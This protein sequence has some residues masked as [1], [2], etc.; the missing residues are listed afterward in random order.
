MADISVTDIGKAFGENVILEHISF[1]IQPGQHVGLVGANGTGKTSLFRMLSGEWEPDGGSIHV[2]RGRRVGLLAQL[3]R[4]SPGATVEDVLRGAFAEREALADQLRELEDKMSA[5]T[6]DDE[7][8]R[9]YGELQSRFEASGGYNSDVELAKVAAGLDITHLLPREFERISGGE[10]TRANLARLILADTDILLLDEP[11]N[12]LD[13]RSVEW[14]E[15]YLSACRST[16]IIVSHDR[17]FLDRT[18]SR[19]IELEFHTATVWEGN[20][21]AYAMQKE[22]RLADQEKRWEQEQREIARLSH[23]AARMHGWGMGNSKLQKRAFALDK[24]IERLRQTEKV[25]RDNVVYKGGF[26]DAEESGEEVLELHGL[27]KAFGDHVLFSEAEGFIRKGESV[28]ILGDNGT[29]KTT[30]LKILLGDE[31]SDA[32]KVRWGAN[33]R[34]AYLPQVVHFDN[35]ALT[36]LDTLCSALKL[37]PP[38]GRNRLA[39]YHFTGDDVFKPV[40][41]LSGGEKSRLALCILMYSEIN[42]LILDE[43]TNHLDIRSREWLESALEEYEGTLIFVSHDRYFVRRFATKIWQLEGG[44][45]TEFPD[46]YE[47]YEAVRRAAPAAPVKAEPAKEK[48]EKPVSADAEVKRNLKADRKRLAAVEREI[49]ALEA[50]TAENAKRQELAAYDA[51]ALME[52]LAEAEELSAALAPL[53]DEW[54]ELSERI[55]EELQ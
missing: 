7:D 47:R 15:D 51:A 24:R 19:I 29:G 54:A 21:S 48:K 52:A 38:S 55:P 2:A 32:G 33:I 53:Y 14:L 49:A 18:V 10:Q 40:S 28:A 23:T 3:P 36:V 9:R 20:Y 31:V 41:A 12:H 42:V 37:T 13:I 1:E 27:S 44:Q 5:G 35:E 46:G 8:L 16:V 25:R 39:A 30:L 34:K 43:P 6:A 26:K 4:F 11:T 22:Q 17:W 45:I 50:K